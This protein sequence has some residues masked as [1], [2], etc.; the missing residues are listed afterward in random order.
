MTCIALRPV[1]GVN[2]RAGG[3]AAQAGHLERVDD[4]LGAEVIG[5]RPA[6]DTA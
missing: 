6:D 1:V 4:E 3:L 5:D 2:G